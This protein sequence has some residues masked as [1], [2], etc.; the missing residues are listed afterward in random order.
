MQAK[1]VKNKRLIAWN[2]VRLQIP[3]D[4]DA[5]VAGKRH[6]VFEKDFQL[7]LQIRWEKPS[8]VIPSSF[9]ERSKRIAE[10]LGSIIQAEQLPLELQKLHDVFGPVTCY[11]GESGLLEG[12]VF[13]CNDHRT[14]VFFQLSLPNPALVA[15]VSNC[16]TTFA[17]CDDDRET[18]WRIQD[19]SLSLPGSYIL[20]DYTFGAGLTRISFSNSTLLLQTC[21]LGPAD[22]RLSRQSLE[23]I[24]ITLAGSS[25]LEPVTAKGNVCCEAHRNPSIS[26]QL[27]F[28]LRREK[29]FIRS[30]LWHDAVNNRLLAVMLSSN[31]PIALKTLYKI[32][33]QYE[34]IPEENIK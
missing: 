12:G 24:L 17:C 10:Q 5:R 2:G 14:P 1:P 8:R 3:T 11:R 15:E 34:I 29:P 7:Q 27:L 16:L 19:L 32:C 20:N 6:L 30:K 31:R 26:G 4:W 22:S 18:L 25:G 9:Q 21:K 23:K 28:R 13:C 33:G